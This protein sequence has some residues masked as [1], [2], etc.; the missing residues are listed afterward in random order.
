MPSPIH[1]APLELF[2]RNPKVV[3]A[4]LR[5]AGIPIPDEA[6]ATTGS[7][8]MS[9]VTTRQYIADHLTVFTDTAGRAI[10]VT[11]NEPQREPDDSKFWSWPVYL[12]V[13]RSRHKCPAT[14]LVIC[15]DNRTADWARRP[16]D[17]GH[18]GFVLR[19]LVIDA[20]NTPDPADPAF[21]EVAPEL[22]VL[23]AHTGAL[24]LDD[25]QARDLAVATVS[26]LDA[27][28]AALY[29]SLILNVAS[30]SARIALEA[31][32]ASTGIKIDPV[33][34]R[35]AQNLERLREEAKAEGRALG[36]AEGRALGEAEGRALGEA[37]GR[38]LGEAEG[39]AEMLLLIA[40]KR[41]IAVDDETRDR[42]LRCTDNATIES[43]A[44]QVLTGSTAAQIFKV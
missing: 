32:M 24:D 12:T 20:S 10:R 16:I 37:E 28:R 25:A 41:G 6:T 33:A 34:A 27:D 42:V 35:F 44:D 21:A 9:I 18:P 22:V 1:E 5:R 40:A 23:A 26:S 13:A 4:L 39:Q 29:A 30:T 31:L 7:A 36:E 8:D 17:T 3:A 43:W 11:V 15:Y 19:P 14:L 2:R 38:A